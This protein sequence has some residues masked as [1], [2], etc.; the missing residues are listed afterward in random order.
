VTGQ[1]ARIVRNLPRTPLP[2]AGAAAGRGDRL[3]VVTDGMLERDA[4]DLDVNR[5]SS[6]TKRTTTRH[7][8]EGIRRLASAESNPSGSP[9]RFR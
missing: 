3:F 4:A 6:H 1:L 8:A 9:T 5:R 7:T 2:R